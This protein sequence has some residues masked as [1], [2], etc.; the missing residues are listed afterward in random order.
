MTRARRRTLA[1]TLTIVCTSG[2]VAGAAPASAEDSTFCP[3]SSSTRL[4]TAND[5]DYKI[6]LYQPGQEV[7]V[8]WAA[9]GA[10]GGAF[11][12]RTGLGGTLV[13]V[14]TADPNDTT[15]PAFIHVQEPVDLMTRLG[16]ATSSP[17]S[18]CIGVGGGNAV[19]VTVTTPTGTAN[20]Q[21]EIWLDGGTSVAYEY[22]DKV[23]PDRTSCFEDHWS[24]QN[25]IRVI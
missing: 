12:F 24:G 16:L 20:P 11:V 1:A 9:D 3:Q 14:V 4:L 23:A 6:W 8:C 22:C 21:A 5:G 19:R 25:P 18:V 13:P 2:L 15:C 7:H 17:Y 10:V